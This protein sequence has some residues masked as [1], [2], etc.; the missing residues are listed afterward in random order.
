MTFHQSGLSFADPAS[1]SL[2]WASF[3]RV[4]SGSE[5][6]ASAACLWLI[7]ALEDTSVLTGTE[8]LWEDHILSHDGWPSGQR[9][10]AVQ[11]LWRLQDTRVLPSGTSRDACA[12]LSRRA[13]TIAPALLAIARHLEAN[14]DVINQVSRADYGQ[15]CER[16]FAALRR[17]LARENGQFDRDESWYP[18]E[19]VELVAHVPGK[20]GFVECSA[21]LLLNSLAT[22]DSQGHFESRWERMGAA[23]IDLQEPYRVPILRGIRY[24]YEADQNFLATAGTTTF[25]SGKRRS[26]LPVPA[27][28]V[29]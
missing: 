8:G 25:Q 22:R 26:I 20:P 16:H 9:A 29:L 15:D 17:V 14:D 11:A 10:A 21:L 19:V 27:I 7:A 13:E 1:H 2:L 4:I 5:D 18:S 24:L 3:D 12:G 28:P 6:C 23:Y